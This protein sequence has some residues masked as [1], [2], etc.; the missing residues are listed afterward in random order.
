MANVTATLE[1]CCSAVLFL[2]GGQNRHLEAQIT[3][4]LVGSLEFQIG[5][6]P[7]LFHLFVKVYVLYNNETTSLF[8]VFFIFCF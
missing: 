4:L 2:T 8:W 6:V 1:L 7:F 3:D 5:S